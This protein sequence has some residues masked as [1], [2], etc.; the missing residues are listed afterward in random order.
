MIHNILARQG[1][2]CWNRVCLNFQASALRDM[3]MAAQEGCGTGQK[4][5][6]RFSLC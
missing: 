3:K 6:N 2:S 4:N 5:S 1:S